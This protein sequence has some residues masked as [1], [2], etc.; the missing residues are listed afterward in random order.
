MK[1]CIV[2]LCIYYHT[3][4]KFNGMISILHMISCN[5]IKTKLFISHEEQDTS[6]LC[7][8]KVT[9]LMCPF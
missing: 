1:A 3:I 4:Y 9:S 7:S 2:Y 6:L 8:N 5:N